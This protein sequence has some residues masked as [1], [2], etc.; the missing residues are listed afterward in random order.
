MICCSH[1]YVLLGNVYKVT[2]VFLTWIILF[3]YKHQHVYF[4]TKHGFNSKY[5]STKLIIQLLP[6]YSCFSSSYI[7]RDHH[8]IPVIRIKF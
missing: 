2:N 7:Y 5:I 4:R 6:T 3:S 8:N 1:D